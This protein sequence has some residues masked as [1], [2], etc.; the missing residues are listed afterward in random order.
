MNPKYRFFMSINGGTEFAVNPV[1][2]D[3]SKDYAKESGQMFFRAKLNGQLTFVR[4][5]YAK[6]SES[7]FDSVFLFR[8]E[9]YINSSWVEYWRGNFYKT[10]CEFD[11]DSETCKVTPNVVDQ[12]SKIL[13]GYESEMDL[14]QLT[15][16]MQRINYWKRPIFQ[17]YIE[18]SN[19]IGCFQMG[20]YWE[21]EAKPTTS[22]NTLRYTYKFGALRYYQQAKVTGASIADINNVFVGYDYNGHDGIFSDSFP[23]YGR[24][25]DGS[26]T[27]FEIQY[28][29]Q[30]IFEDTYYSVYIVKDGVQ[31][32]GATQTESFARVLAANP[33]SGATGTATITYGRSYI[34]YGRIV[35]DV[36]PSSQ[37]EQYELPPDD[38]TDTSGYK[39]G[40]PM[41]VSTGGQYGWEGF[42]VLNYGFS[43]EATQFGQYYE[44]GESLGYYDAP[45]YQSTDRYQPISRNSWDII[46]VWLDN[47]KWSLINLAN[48]F[49]CKPIVLKDAYS[50]AS[51]IQKI[52]KAIDPSLDFQLTNDY[53]YLMATILEQILYI[54]PK[55]N[56]L[57]SEYDQP[58]QQAPVTL[59]TLWM[60]CAI[61][62][63]H[64]GSLKIIN[65]RL[66]GLITLPT[67]GVIPRQRKRALI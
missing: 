48:N 12:Y 44:N 1:Y 61:C 52:V 47:T 50:F 29:I 11:S 9:Q 5:D 22:Y 35:N 54:T 31:Y 19:T 67:V 3:L 17:F 21:Q 33:A 51:S 30:T 36:G 42:I 53:S 28:Q 16:D 7:S 15:P 40:E 64:I 27:G 23:L 32:Y 2:K 18:G 8:I 24:K 66:K 49:R 57:V 10:D 38:I 58:A 25:Q 45:P 65:S 26:N 13:A 55:T 43:S 59:K 37:P 60:P 20:V 6:I 56:I 46:S 62:S 4:Q 39:Y 41:G 34:V 63:M 14:I